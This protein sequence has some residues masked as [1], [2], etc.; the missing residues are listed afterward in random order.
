MKYILLI[1]AFILFSSNLFA[2]KDYQVLASIEGV[3][4]S[5]KWKHSKVCKK[6]SPLMLFLKLKNTNDYPVNINV[7]VDYFWQGI[8]A[9]SSEPINLCIKS[10][11]SS[12]GRIKKLTFDRSRFSDADILSA[13]FTLDI[14]SVKI[15]QVNHCKKKLKLSQ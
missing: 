15:I 10:N 11:R 4:V 12:K 9:A 1:S 14:S 2:Q 7:T 3:E 8:R 13:E 6:D 5:N